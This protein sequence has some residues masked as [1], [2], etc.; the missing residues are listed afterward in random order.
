[1]SQADSSTVELGKPPPKGV[2][3]IF[4]RINVWVYRLSGGK[5]MNKLGG[6]PIC[7]VTMT[8]ARSGKRR[9]IPLMYVPYGDTILLVASQGGMPRHPVWYNNLV[10]NPDVTIEEGGL[11][12]K[13]RAREVAGEERAQLWPVCVEHYADYDLYRQRTEREIPVFICEPITQ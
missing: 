9:T 2:L 11:L 5:L 4:T 3:K 1:M 10:A 8:G 7:L 12:R 13:L 6:D